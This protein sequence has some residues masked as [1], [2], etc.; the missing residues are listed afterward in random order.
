MSPHRTILCGNTRIIVCGARSSIW[1]NRVC[2][3]RSEHYSGAS[4]L[5]HPLSSLR[6]HTDVA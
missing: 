6:S 5:Q 3:V 4:Q 2:G 1:I